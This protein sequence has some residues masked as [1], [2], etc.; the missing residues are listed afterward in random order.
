MSGNN[1]ITPIGFSP[2]PAIAPGL[3]GYQMKISLQPGHVNIYLIQGDDGWTIIDTGVDGPQERAQWQQFLAAMP[4]KRIAAVLV[5]HHHAD[6]IGLAGWLC[7]QLDVP[8]ITSAT[9]YANA[10]AQQQTRTDSERIDLAALYAQH[11]MADLQVAKIMGREK[12]F[13]SLVSNLPAQFTVLADGDCL[14]IGV[15]DFSVALH[16]GHAPG[17]IVLHSTYHRLLLIGDQ[18]I[19]G[20]KPYVGLWLEEKNSDPMGDYLASLTLLSQQIDDDV[21]VLA[22]HGAPFRGVAQQSSALIAKHLSRRERLLAACEKAP[23]TVSDLIPLL[24]RPH[25]SAL[26]QNLAFAETHAYIRNLVVA[27]RLVWEQGNDGKLR[28]SHCSG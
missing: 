18:L 14:K 10:L 2:L 13:R 3:L 4:D 24:F 26:Q 16:N 8:L 28:V 7:A 25:L 12:Q 15:F 5:T 20:V 21:L 23:A 19:N 6:H 27:G 17:Q 11:G 1:Q 9:S 22:G